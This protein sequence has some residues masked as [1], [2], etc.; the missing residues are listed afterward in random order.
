MAL[1]NRERFIFLKR[2]QHNGTFLAAARKMQTAIVV[3]RMSLRVPGDASDSVVV[4]MPAFDW[5]ARWYVP[6][7]DV[8]C[9]TTSSKI[10]SVGRES[11]HTERP[12]VAN[13]GTVNGEGFEVG[14]DAFADV[15]DALKGQLVFLFLIVDACACTWNRVFCYPAPGLEEIEVARGVE[16]FLQVE[17]VSLDVT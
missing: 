7:L 6:N 1:K 5:C 9:P 11:G 4:T 12:F 10:R 3:T 17:S 8:A 14:K 13:L 16:F 2:P 15:D